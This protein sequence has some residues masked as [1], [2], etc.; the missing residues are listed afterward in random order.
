MNER[1]VLSRSELVSVSPA[2][3]TSW[4]ENNS[5]GGVLR[6]LDRRI[7]GDERFETFEGIFNVVH[8]IKGNRQVPRPNRSFRPP[9]IERWSIRAASNRVSDSRSPQ[10]FREPLSRRNRR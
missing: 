8:R 10:P 1:P 7:I 9:E 4:N 6:D 5:H 3:L 2:P